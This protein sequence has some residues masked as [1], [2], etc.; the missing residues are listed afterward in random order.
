MIAKLILISVV[1]GYIL[2][3][4]CYSI[5][6]ECIL[7]QCPSG[8]QCIAGVCCITDPYQICKDT[9]GEDFCKRYANR[10]TDPVL[11]QQMKIICARTFENRLLKMICK[12]IIL[13]TVAGFALGQSC[14]SIQGG[15]ILGQCPG[16]GQCIANV[17]CVTDAA[18]NCNNT[19]DDQFCDQHAA[20]CTDPT[21]G[22]QMKTICARTCKS[23][24]GAGTN[25]TGTP[26]GTPSSG[27]CAD[28]VNPSTGTSDCPQ[29][30]YLC[31]DP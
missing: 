1:A 19:M 23:C 20:A 28:K 31:N 7:G 5:Q 14:L 8:A 2:G 15:C 13:M 9:E 3:E 16:G 22:P 12:L 24:N 10:C 11:G 17:C 4:T 30:Q 26:S 6:G 27:A 29:D 18:S 25:S 21:A